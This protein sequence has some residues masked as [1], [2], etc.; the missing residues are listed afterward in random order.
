M[1]EVVILVDEHDREAGV[2]GKLAV[3]TSGSLHRAFSVFVFNEGNEMLIQRRAH[4]KYHS[5]GLWSNACCG[6]PRPGESVLESAERRL[7]EEMG[8]VIPLRERFSFLYRADLGSGLI[9]YEYDHVLLGCFSGVPEPS[10]DEVSEWR[11]VGLK[12][13][14]A[15]IAS[16]PSRYAIWFRI[17]LVQMEARNLLNELTRV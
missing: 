17:A 9:E 8:F 5:P 6:H 13:L 3:H 12:T 11:W 4:T 7:W 16:V 15:D 10:A 2:A 14:T 1:E